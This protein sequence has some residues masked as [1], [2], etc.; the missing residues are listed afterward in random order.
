MV[1]PCVKK[2][3]KFNCVFLK[4]LKS[5]L[6]SNI[7]EIKSLIIEVWAFLILGIYVLRHC[8]V[9]TFQGYGQDQ[10]E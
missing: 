6:Q 10:G 7:F 2:D 1:G 9:G 5:L 8:S 3:I 4:L